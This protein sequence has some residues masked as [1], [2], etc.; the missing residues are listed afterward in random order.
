L[1]LAA[2][3]TASMIPI[4]DDNPTHRTP[5]VTIAVIAACIL[6]FLW[7]LSLGEQGGIAVYRYGFIP[8]VL[9]G[10]ASLP[11]EVAAVP[12]T[13]TLV[14]SMFLHGGLLHLGG[15]MLYLWIFGN[16]IEDLCGHRRYALFYVLCGL[17]AAFAQALPDPASEVPMIGASGAISGVLGAYLIQFPHARVQVLVPIGILFFTTVPAGVLLGIWFLFQLLSGAMTPTE[18]GGVAF[19][20]HVGGFVAGLALIRWFRDPAYRPPRGPLG[21]RSAGGRSRIPEAGRRPWD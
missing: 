12:A 15:N 19:W 10:Q 6:V 1:A 17:V 4:R 8:A 21:R 11:P 20:A 16:N 5:Y 9:F 14:T 7:Q 18:G 13:L 2:E 3:R